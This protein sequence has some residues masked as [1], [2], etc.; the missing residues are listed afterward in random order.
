ML[1]FDEVSAGWRD[2][3]GGR[4]LQYGVAPD[5]ATFSKTISNGFVTA[6]AGGGL[7]DT[8]L[9][10][11]SGWCRRGFTAQFGSVRPAARCFRLRFIASLRAARLCVAAASSSWPH[12]SCPSPGDGCSGRAQLGHAGHPGHLHLHHVPHR[13]HRP[14][15]S[16]PPARFRVASGSKTGI[17]ARAQARTPWRA[18]LPVRL[19][20]CGSGSFGGAHACPPR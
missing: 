5:I 9:A 15:P 8:Q 1:V 6:R 3:C 7:H 11:S 18:S 14:V 19:S 17:R 10:P 16:P 12:S 20:V 2:V 13:A 4:H